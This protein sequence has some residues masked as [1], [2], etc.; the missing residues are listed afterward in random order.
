V[1]TLIRY[2]FSSDIPQSSV[3]AIEYLESMYRM[4]IEKA[5]QINLSNEI[6]KVLRDIY[7]FNFEGVSI[8][9]L[10]IVSITETALKKYTRSLMNI[11]LGF[12]ND[13]EYLVTT[14]KMYGALAM[15]RTNSRKILDISQLL[16]SKVE[17]LGKAEVSSAL[18][19][20]FSNE[21]NSNDQSMLVDMTK[22]LQ[23]M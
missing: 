4:V 2:G 12:A 3:L 11:L 8:D 5:D 6:H 22:I 17:I 15:L 13:G 20:H 23:K 18:K 14:E 16:K 10:P 19:K 1:N 7:P 21:A 9:N